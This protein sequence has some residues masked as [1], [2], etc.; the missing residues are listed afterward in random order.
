MF[1]YLKSCIEFY[2]FP[3][4]FPP[5]GSKKSRVEF[6]S[7]TFKMDWTVIR[8]KKKSFRIIV[9]AAELKNE[10]RR[11]VLVQLLVPWSIMLSLFGLLEA[12]GGDTAFP[13]VLFKTLQK[14]KYEASRA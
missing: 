10:K 7:M 9:I 1:V 8:N 13:V 4:P 6:C 12:A 11:N 5:I 14:T 2:Y 3:F